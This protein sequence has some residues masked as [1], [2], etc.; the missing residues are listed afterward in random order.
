MAASI[1]ARLLGPVEF[2]I[3][4]KVLAMSSLKDRALLA[5]LCYSPDLEHRRET[6]AGLLWGE[7]EAAKARDS[8]K[9]AVGRMRNALGANDELLR[10]TRTTVAIVPGVARTD[11]A[12]FLELSEKNDVASLAEAL[13]LYRGELLADILL[14]E[15]AFDDWQIAERGRIRRAA[16][17]VVNRNLA[18]CTERN[19][20][21]ASIRVARR[22]LDIDPSNERACRLLMRSLAEAGDRSNAITTFKTFTAELSRDLGI[23]PEAETVA[24][25]ERLM[26]PS[27]RLGK[28][29]AAAPEAH[30]GESVPGRPSVA[31]LAF[32]PLGIE[33][34]VADGMTEEVVTAL[35][36][37]RGISLIAHGSSF[38][39]RD[40]SRSAGELGRELGALY[41]VE[42]KI[43]QQADQLRAMVSLIDVGGR[44]VIWSD[45]FTGMRNDLFAMQE[46]IA[47]QIAGGLLPRVEV[48]EISRAT[49]RHTA[50]RDAYD[51][52]LRGLSCMHRWTEEDT[53]DAIAFFEEATRIAPDFAAAYAMAVRCYSLRKA[54]GWVRDRVRETE[55]ARRLSRLAADLAGDDALPLSMAAIGFGFVAGE[56]EKGVRLIERALQ[57]NPNLAIAW[58]FS[59]WINVWLGLHETAIEHFATAMRLSPHDPQFAL[60][61]G[62]TAC[63]HLLS[64]R[65]D[66]AIA[67]AEKAVAARPN[68]WIAWCA[69]AAARAM[70]GDKDDAVAALDHVLK[71]DPELDSSNLLEAFPLKRNEDIEIWTRSL[72]L[73]GLPDR[74]P[75][76]NPVASGAA[77][78]PLMPG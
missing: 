13:T 21:E 71:I 26:S 64:D 75:G 72:R 9:H 25:Y 33:D 29:G 59:G 57:L 37:V 24:L 31:I 78:K 45:T 39:Y 68:Y 56:P 28:P 48:A 67:W 61:Q 1:E 46:Q 74:V 11:A 36:R 63:A 17:Y 15:E 10:V 54:S 30:S 40:S 4:G 76:D 44:R 5:Y 19:D 51:F 23:A 42:G 69:L 41:L 2:L 34:Y 73:A 27:G 49:S 62:G 32:K 50:P 38:S 65:P 70:T 22:A 12:R 52:Y 43:M 60:M 77:P 7:S 58:F 14:D 6:L 8:L 35:S 18:F 16:D 53:L 3:D 47:A 55:E 20:F 66:Q